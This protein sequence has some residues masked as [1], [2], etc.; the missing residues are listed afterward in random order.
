MTRCP[1]V[2]LWG[3]AE[4]EMGMTSLV[5]LA[6][7][8]DGRMMDNGNGTGWWVMALFVVV[9]AVA[10]IVLIVWFATRTAHPQGSPP[11][12]PNLRARQILAE[13]LARGEIDPAEYQERLAHLP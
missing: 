8:D 9:M 2:T 3:T 5:L 6:D 10:A 7:W 12:D 4:E 11:G 13:R 1:S